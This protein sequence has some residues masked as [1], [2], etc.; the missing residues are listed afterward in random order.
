MF[1]LSK[2]KTVLEVTLAFNK[3]ADDLAE[4]AHRN[5][6]EQVIQQQI[7]QQAE[8]AKKAAKSESNLAMKVRD[9]ILNIL[10]ANED[11]E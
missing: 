5:E 2:P 8:A 11:T 4:I 6:E 9:N 10:E 3:M 1:G 7:I